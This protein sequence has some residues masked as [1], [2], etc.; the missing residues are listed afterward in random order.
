MRD[1]FPFPAPAALVRLAKPLSEYFS[2]TT[3]PLHIHELLFATLVYFGIQTYVSPWISPRLFP[4]T[5][6]KLNARTK[7]NWDVHVV[8]F[9]QSV[10][11]SILSF[12]IMAKD[13]ERNQMPW[14]ERIHGYSPAVGMVAAFGA[15]YFLWDLMVTGWNMSVFGI[16]MLMHAV[17][18]LTVFLLGFV[19]LISRFYF[20]YTHPNYF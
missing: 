11:I 18:A 1:P 9:V 12:W 10:I 17:S 3:L 19:R 15:G 20:S 2:L 7:L 8:S 16:G 13:D 14:L 5:Y 6:P 4:Q